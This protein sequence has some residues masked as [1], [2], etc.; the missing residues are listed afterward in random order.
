M[1]TQALTHK[2]NIHSNNRKK[3]L[4]SYNASPPFLFLKLMDFSVENPTDDTTI[5]GNHFRFVFNTNYS[6]RSDISLLSTII[7]GYILGTR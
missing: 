5:T 6:I 1:K 2:D 7:I 4:I 3:L